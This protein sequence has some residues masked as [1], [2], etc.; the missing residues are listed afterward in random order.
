MRR[1]PSSTAM[2]VC[3]QAATP[4]MTTGRAGEWYRA[5]SRRRREGR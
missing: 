5:L 4:V 1:A 2:A 3:S